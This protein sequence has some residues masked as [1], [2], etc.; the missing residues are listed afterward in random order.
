MAQ[1]TGAGSRRSGCPGRQ[2]R[3]R[4]NDPRV[5]RRILPDMSRILILLLCAFPALAGANEWLSLFNGKNLDGWSGDPR[6]WRVEEGVLI[7]ESNDTD[8]KPQA[9]TFLIWT[10]GEPADFTLEYKARLTGKNNSGVQYRSRVTDAGKWRVTGYQMD[11]H[12]NQP[13]LGMLY[14]EGGRGIVCLRGQKVKLGDK[15]E[16]TGKLDVPEVDLGEWN[17]YRV[18]A[19]GNLLRH[20]VNGELAAEIEDVHPGKSS[21]K[22]VIA[23][24][25]HSGPP[26]KVEF[27]ELRL[28]KEGP[29]AP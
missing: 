10:E 25:L 28:K 27:K 8:K 2:F 24:Q 4:V 11:L 18:V 3:F 5:G 1:A 29:S 16:V 15:P 12:P 6:L 26:M 20:Y 17:E 7:G 22:G 9:N 13:Y 21:A 23:L 19:R 14:E